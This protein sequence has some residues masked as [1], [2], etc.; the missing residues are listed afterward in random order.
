MLAGGLRP[1]RSRSRSMAQMSARRRTLALWLALAALA[2][3]AVVV[4]A[5]GEA[6]R[7][8]RP[9]AR[10][11]A[12]AGGEAEDR[13]G[14]GG[15]DAENAV[16]SP[17]RREAREAFQRRS[18]ARDAV[19]TRKRGPSA[20]ELLE[21]YGELTKK[22]GVILVGNGRSVLRHNLGRVIDSFRNVGRFNHFRTGG[23]EAFVGRKTTLCFASDRRHPKG[24]EKRADCK[25]YIVPAIAARGRPR[26]R[27]VPMIRG[28]YRG[29]GL[30]SKLTIL[31]AQV[32]RELGK[33]Y[34]LR[35]GPSTGIQAILYM[36]E[37]E[38]KVVITGF[39]F[40]SRSHTHYFEKKRKKHTSH[41]MSGETRIIN[42]LIAKGRII[43]IP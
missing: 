3:C 12:A 30:Q 33:K 25:R 4:G 10:R 40:G 24:I 34:G 41:S 42:Q 17:Q 31:P 26:S 11:A 2:A 16:L 18:L 32:E 13:R 5:A 36:L 35:A 21:K 38:E 7:E 19:R 37:K 15:A 1:E 39:D 14:G 9:G 27:L 23:F 29:M 22:V 28:W 20:E 43:R 8:I 6:E